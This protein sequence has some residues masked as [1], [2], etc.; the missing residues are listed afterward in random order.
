MLKSEVGTC[1]LNRTQMFA[2]I[3]RATKVRRITAMKRSRT[4]YWRS[5]EAP[6][7][8][9]S[10]RIDECIFM[11]VPSMP[12]ETTETVS[13]KADVTKLFQGAESASSS[14]AESQMACALHVALI[15]FHDR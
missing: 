13:P 15:P 12:Y 3:C 2:T 7:G 6:S 5:P 4:L 1:L 9:A 14:E 11:I 8:F 10:R